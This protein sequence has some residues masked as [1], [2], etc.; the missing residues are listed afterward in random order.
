MTDDTAL[1]DF[2]TSQRWYG[3]KTRDV[4]SATVVDRAKLRDDLERW[5]F[6]ELQHRKRG[7]MEDLK[8]K[9]PQF[10]ADLK[11]HLALLEASLDGR[12][13]LLADQPS[14]ADFAV[15]GALCPLGY[16]AKDVPRDFPKLRTWHQRVAKV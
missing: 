10:L 8:A 6:E 11:Q 9:Q 5:V 13:F 12:D 2:I 7:P 3:S 15:F 16:V 14:L 1:V 4:G